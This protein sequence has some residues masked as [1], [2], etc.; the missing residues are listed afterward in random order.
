MPKSGQY[1]SIWIWVVDWKFQVA[2]LVVDWDIRSGFMVY[3]LKKEKKIP[4]HLSQGLKGTFH[5]STDFCI[6]VQAPNYSLF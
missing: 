6:I 4:F 3:K 5:I 2:V 1:W